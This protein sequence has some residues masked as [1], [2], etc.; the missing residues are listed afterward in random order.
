[1]LKAVM[2]DFGHTIIDELKER[3]VPLA[4]RS[5]DLMPDLLEILPQ[6]KFKMGIWANSEA[7]EKDVRMWLRRAGINEY[8]EWIATS[9]DAGARKPNREFFSYAL[10]KC[11][12]K[13]EEIIFVG[14]QLNTDIRGA[15]DYGIQCVWLSGSAY[16]SPDDFSINDIAASQFE[17]DH[18]IESLRELPALLET[19]RQRPPF[20]S[21]LG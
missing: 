19:T 7:G 11:E 18:M 17:P 3:Q 4:S 14:N 8:F 9:K 10:N 15:K 2:F 5:V 1:M 21:R 20:V 16:R 12:M 6:I 13:K